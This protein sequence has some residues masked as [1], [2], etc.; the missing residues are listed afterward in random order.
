MTLRDR[1]LIT[2][3]EHAGRI[4]LV[5]GHDSKWVRVRVTD[6]NWPFPVYAW[7]HRSGYTPVDPLADMPE[8]LV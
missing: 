7:V 8:A 3:G 2:S 5:V 6:T 1:V 4:G